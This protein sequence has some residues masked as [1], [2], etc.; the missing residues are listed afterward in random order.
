MERTPGA[1]GKEGGLGRYGKGVL[2]GTDGSNASTVE[3]VLGE[4][5]IIGSGM[6]FER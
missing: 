3:A 2:T 4:Y 5:R 1:G 6:A